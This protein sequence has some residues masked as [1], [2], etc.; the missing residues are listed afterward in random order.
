MGDGRP[1]TPAATEGPPYRSRFFVLCS[2]FFVLTA[3]PLALYHPYYL[4]YFNPLLGGGATAQRVMLVGLG[5]GMDQIGAWLR[6]RPDLKRGPV[7]SWI[8]PTLAPFVPAAPGVLDLRVQLLEQPTSYAVL[9]ARSVQRQESTVAE[10]YVRQ[11]PPLFTLRMYGIEYATIHQLPRPFDAPLDAQFGEGLRLR[12][13]SQ[14]REGQT[15]TITPS[16]DVQADQPG[17]RFC[18]CTCARPRRAAGGP[19]RRAARPGHVPSMAGRPAVRHALPAPAARRSAA[20]PVPRGDG[21]L[22][23]R[24]RAS[25]AAARACRPAELDGPDALLVTTLAV[26]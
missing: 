14:Q 12:G 24:W 19:D 2:L 5:E 15:L 1:T 17:G 18:L 10:A 7:L 4:A 21:R 23:A 8:P 26:P 3:V 20:R 16:W 25:A 9:Y 6:A 22:H 11:T 13:F